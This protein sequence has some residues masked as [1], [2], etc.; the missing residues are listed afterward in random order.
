M[1][2]R[3]RSAWTRFRAGGGWTQRVW[4]LGQVLRPVSVSTG[5]LFVVGTPTHDAWHAAAHLDDAAAFCGLPQLRP[6]LLRWQ[7]PACAP[8]HLRLSV[9]ELRRSGRG[10]AVLVVAPD[11]LGE[12]ELERL[13]DARRSGATLL[14]VTTAAQGGPLG[15]EL[16]GIADQ[17]AAVA[18]CEDMSF[19]SHL[20]TVS[21]GTV[22]PDRRR[23]ARR[24]LNKR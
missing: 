17:C 12:H 8:Q 10:R 18:G 1:D 6:A 9:D 21:A 2:V 7:P 3:D 13:A 19:A 14:A 11:A 16:A 24:L 20:V 15:G 4:E 22:V 5:Q 23:F